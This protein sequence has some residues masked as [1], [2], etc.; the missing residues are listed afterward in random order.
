MALLL[1]SNLATAQE[2]AAAPTPVEAWVSAVDRHDADAAFELLAPDAREG[3]TR[4]AFRAYF[5]RNYD[6]I[7]RQ[8]E[9][10]RTPPPAPVLRAI[11]PVDGSSV[12]LVRDG[13]RWLIEDPVAPFLPANGLSAAARSA[14]LLARSRD[15]QALRRL[16]LTDGARVALDARLLV[17]SR[18]LAEAGERLSRDPPDGDRVEIPLPD[19]SPI[20]LLRTQNGWR[21]DG[22][23]WLLPR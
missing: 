8:A 22:L 13:E 20:V 5:E 16:L 19:G 15:L 11:V 21:M 9:G 10:L 4:E 12:H 6:L 7:H 2:P 3:M 17:A 14:A 23:E 1:P 18:V